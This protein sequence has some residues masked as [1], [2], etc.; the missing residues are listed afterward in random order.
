[1]L[2][3]DIKLI[4]PIQKALVK[5]NYVEATP[6]QAKSI[7]YILDGHDLF[8]IAQTGTGKTAAFTLPILQLMYEK[9]GNTKGKI[10]TLILAPTRELAAQIGVS[11][12]EYGSFTK[13]NST[14]IFGGVAQQPQEKSLARQPQIVIATPGRL[15][16]L[17]NQKKID[18]S[19]I[20]YFILD[21]ADRMLDMGFI[22]DVKK[23]V[24]KL[25]T[26]KQSLFFSATMSKTIS[27][28]GKK[29][30]KNPKRVEVAP[31]ATTIE[32]INQALYFVDTKNKDKL[33]QDLIIKNNI[34]TGIV[35][36]RTKHKSNK[37]AKFLNQNNIRSEAIHGNKSQ[38]QRTNALNDF[39]AGKI[40]ILVATEI[41][42]RGIDINDI[43]HVINYEIPNEPESYV[44]RIGR[45]GRAGKSGIAFSFCAADERD[46]IR[47]IEKI[48][49]MKIPVIEHELHSNTA[50][51]AKG[52]DA[53]PLPKGQ[54]HKRAKSADLHP[55]KVAAAKKKQDKYEK[56]KD[57]HASKRKNNY[58]VVKAKSKNPQK[59]PSII[60]KDSTNKSKGAV[61]STSK[62]KNYQNKKNSRR[63]TG[64]EKGKENAPNSRTITGGFKSRTDSK[65]KDNSVKNKKNFNGPSKHFHK[66]SNYSKK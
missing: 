49:D 39:K 20:E 40:R 6:I 54:L 8:G 26:K 5:T 59:K 66:K 23:I 65:S 22:N 38:S 19:S 41:V 30:L 43:S 32:K 60:Y 2:F 45:T 15:L 63:N 34:K 18:L 24:S 10:K 46:Y 7:P 56:F 44:H 33:L 11:I 27:D 1:M 14:V 58:N 51:F 31:E 52:K 50:Q 25:P 17:M 47:S 57:E 42:A 62:K 21:E 36:T 9:E 64:E 53:K 35:F 16:D 29:F 13:F 37:I 4:E 61:S 3:K 55:D 48:I 28:L 12:I